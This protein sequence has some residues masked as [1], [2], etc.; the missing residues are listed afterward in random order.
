[1]KHPQLSAVVRQANALA[2]VAV[3]PA[4]ALLLAAG[5]RSWAL[6]LCV[7]ALVA[8]LNATMLTRRMERAANAPPWQ[9]PRIMAQGLGLRFAMVLLATVVVVKVD[10]DSIPGF[11]V[12]LLVTMA[13]GIAIAARALLAASPAPRLERMR[14]P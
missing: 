1:L 13:L 10:P 6:G 9:A 12:G 3:L 8:M 5:R 2:L 14:L 11:L 7:G 4:A